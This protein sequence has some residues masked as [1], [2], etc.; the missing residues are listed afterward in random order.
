VV[1]TSP[2]FVGDCCSLRRKIIGLVW[3]VF[4]A[5]F[6]NILVISWQSVLLVEET[7]VPGENHQP[8]ESHWQT[9]SHN[10][11]SSSPRHELS[12]LVVIDYTGSC[13]SNNHTI[14]T[15]NIIDI[16]K[17]TEDFFGYKRKLIIS[18]RAPDKLR[19]CV[20]YAMKTSK[21]ACI[22]RSKCTH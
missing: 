12:T 5:T 8:A 21:N 1:S 19:I 7:G 13:N 9:L 10:V 22:I 3:L 4:G 6:N 18:I 17:G 2:D 16:T 14:T 20:F 15:T 11:V